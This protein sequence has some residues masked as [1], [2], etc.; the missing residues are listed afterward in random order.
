MLFPPLEETT[1][2]AAVT[3]LMQ[4]VLMRRW[5]LERSERTEHND[6]TR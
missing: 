2:N 3:W 6:A 4:E 5:R 1:E